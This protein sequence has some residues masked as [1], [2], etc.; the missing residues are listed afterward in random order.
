MSTNNNHA[1]QLSSPTPAN[2]GGWWQAALWIPLGFA[3]TRLLGDGAPVLWV[4]V[5]AVGVAVVNYIVP[6]L[7]ALS[8]G[9]CALLISLFHA[10]DGQANGELLGPGGTALILGFGSVML[11]SSLMVLLGPLHARRAGH[12]L[13]VAT[14]VLELGMFTL[15]P[16]G[17]T[18]V[19]V[20]DRFTFQAVVGGLLFGLTPVIVRSKHGL[21]LLGTALVLAQ[22]ALIVSGGTTGFSPLACLL[23]TF[24]FAAVSLFFESSDAEEVSDPAQLELGLA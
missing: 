9:G 3:T 15:S 8:V 24:T 4:A 7:T 18:L 6:G 10:V 23:G 5:L 17:Q 2:A 22:G 16:L 13:V 1:T 12:H 11:V 20:Q 21:P 14:G 19:N